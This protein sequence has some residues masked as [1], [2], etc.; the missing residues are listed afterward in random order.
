MGNNLYK[1]ILIFIFFLFKPLFGEI[2]YD[3]N[4]II[5]SKVE[6]QEYQKIYFN[7]YGSKLTDKLSLKKIILQKKTINNLLKNNPEFM[8]N[9]D[10]AIIEEYGGE[11]LN[12]LIKRDFFRFFKI[13]NEFI[14]EYYMKE[15]NIKDLKIILK[16]ID[17]LKIP[18]SQNKCLTIANLVDVKNN[19]DFL[20]NLYLAFR[21]N[22]KN[23][24]ISIN[25]ITYDVCISSKL[26]KEI[27]E[28]IV[29]Y[30]EMKTENN[31]QKFIYRN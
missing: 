20:N 15:F 27:E 25:N 4:N 23:I 21:N 22:S 12:D 30:I 18:I 29:N 17:N 9:L 3:K 31:F 8:K 2:I 28:L 5:I 19:D 26:L 16:D 1:I 7:F 11:I 24:E 6:L 10:K 14:S 13:R